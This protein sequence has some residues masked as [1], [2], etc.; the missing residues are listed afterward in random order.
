MPKNVIIFSDGTGQGEGLTVDERRS[1]VYKLCRACRCGPDSAGDPATQIAFYDPGL[2]SRLAS[3][4]KVGF[5]RRIYN[6]L[7]QATGLGL[8]RNVVDCYAAL[9]R[10]W[11][12]GDRIYLFGFSRGAYTVRCLAGVIALCGVPTAASPEVRFDP[13]ASGRIAAEAVRGVYRHGAGITDDPLKAERHALARRFRD[14]YASDGADGEANAAPY[15]IGVWDTVAALGLPLPGTIQSVLAVVAYLLTCLVAGGVL[16]LLGRV[17]APVAP[18]LDLGYWP[19]FYACVVASAVAVVVL[20]VGRFVYPPRPD[21]SGR[22]AWRFAVSPDNRARQVLRHRPRGEGRLRAPRP[23]HRREQAGLR[24]G[25]V[26]RRGRCARPCRRRGGQ[27][28]AGLVRRVP[29]GRRR[30][31]SGDGVAPVGRRARLDG[32]G[33]RRAAASDRGRSRLPPPVPVRGG[34]SARRGCRRHLGRAEMAARHRKVACRGSRRAGAGSPAPFRRRALRTRRGVPIRPGWTL[35][36]R[37]APRAREG[38]RALP[39]RVPASGY[40]NEFWPTCDAEFW[41]TLRF[42]TACRPPMW[43]PASSQSACQLRISPCAEQWCDGSGRSP[44]PS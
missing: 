3:G 23:F 12:P 31:L 17:L 33:S 38:R 19:A 25:G 13:E 18:M 43:P 10:M 15:L 6:V 26:G 20:G 42:L 32:R 21:L 41:P 44:F 28:E 7:S 16:A 11:E 29:L 8:T 40:D 35:P 1:N 39:L 4:E 27:V 22:R 30:L 24:P 37:A 5:G 36:A 2:G 14:R 9:M 34:G